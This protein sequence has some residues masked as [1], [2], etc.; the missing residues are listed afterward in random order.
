MYRGYNNLIERRGLNGSI[1]LKGVKLTK[2]QLEGLK[3]Y[4]KNTPVIKRCFNNIDEYH[5]IIVNNYL[6]SDL[7][8]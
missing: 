4:I 5:L 8:L 7:I 6:E 3:D 2:W 1:E